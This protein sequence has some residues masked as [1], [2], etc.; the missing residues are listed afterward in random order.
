M[1]DLDIV[2][3]K[4]GGMK[5]SNTIVL[6]LKNTMSDC[7]AAEKLFNELLADCRVEVLPHVATGL[8]E[9]SN[10]EKEILTRMNNFFCG[11]HFIV[12]LAEC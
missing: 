5:V 2:Q 10:T 12:G 4:L 1:E 6:K 11:L 7:N 9:A 8:S 3:D